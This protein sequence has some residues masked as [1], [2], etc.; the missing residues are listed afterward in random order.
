MKLLVFSSPIA[1]SDRESHI[2]DEEAAIN[3][4]RRQGF[5][6]QIYIREDGSGAVTVVQ[7]NSL[8]ECHRK[9]Q[10][11]PFVKYKCILVEAVPV[12][13]FHGVTR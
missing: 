11:L 10:E 9:L 8:A 13:E 4:L 1:G 3:R 12:S 6:E 2:D 5:I 7:A